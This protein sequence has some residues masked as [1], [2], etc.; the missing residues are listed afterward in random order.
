MAKG[1][2]QDCGGKVMQRILADGKRAIPILISQLT[3]TTRTQKQ[4]ADDW[5]DTRS[6]DV[7]YVILTDLFTDADGRT[8]EMPGVPDWPTVMKG[9]NGTAQDCW[10]QYLREHGRKS[11]QEAWLR[12]WDRWKDQM[13]WDSAAR[14][15]RIA[16]K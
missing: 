2:V 11:V 3:E 16:K 5:S 8:F 9:C 7:A 6:G 14:C 10:E 15:F 4:I 1:R 13:H 12:A